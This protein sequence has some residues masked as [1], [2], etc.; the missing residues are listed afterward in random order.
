MMD[1]TEFSFF[2]SKSLK[3]LCVSMIPFD[4]ARTGIVSVPLLNNFS[5]R[6]SDLPGPT[7]LINFKKT[8]P[9]SKSKILKDFRE[10]T[11]NESAVNQLTKLNNLVSNS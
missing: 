5:E 3:R 4:V 6:I 7:L 11:N 1:Q 2:K 8:S 10:N 9:D